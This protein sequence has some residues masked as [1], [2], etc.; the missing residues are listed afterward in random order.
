MRL[1][2]TYMAIGL[3]YQKK[4]V[5]LRRMKL[6]I[7][8]L[9]G[10]M[11]TWGAAAEQVAGLRPAINEAAAAHGVDPV[12]MEAIIRLESGNAT[13]KAARKKNNLAGIMGRRGQRSYA[14]KEDCVKDLARI[15]GN[16][17]AKGRV[18][19]N[20]ISRVYCESRSKWVRGVNSYMGQIRKGRWGALETPAAASDVH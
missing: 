18:T 17:K 19:V 20:E 6:T 9:T 2:L 3:T 11:L 15:L 7:T 16:Y 12:L 10:L 8:I 5:S 14:T 1:I 13:S 4:S